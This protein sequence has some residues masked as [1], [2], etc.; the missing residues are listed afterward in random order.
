[1]EEAMEEIERIRE[2][3]TKE[4]KR[5]R[6]WSFLEAGLWL[7]IA[8]LYI[9]TSNWAAVILIGV[10]LLKIYQVYMEQK[11]VV[12]YR[13]VFELQQKALDEAEK[14]MQEVVKANDEL[15]DT[16]VDNELAE[17]KKEK[18]YGSTDARADR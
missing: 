4:F 7:V 5:L 18:Q 8:P 3:D 6:L 11:M 17:L 10:I 14:M 9:V 16:V 13:S 2:R 12:M 1:M 15:A